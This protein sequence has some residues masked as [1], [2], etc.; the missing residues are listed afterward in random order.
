MKSMTALM[1]TIIYDESKRDKFYEQLRLNI[2]ESRKKR[3][4]TQNELSMLINQSASCINKIEN[5]CCTPT[6]CTII[7]ICVVLDMRLEEIIPYE[8]LE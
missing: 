3:K 6:L 4:V 7:N 2:I 5:G 1:D 8:Y